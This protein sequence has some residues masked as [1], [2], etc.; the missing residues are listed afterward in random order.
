MEDFDKQLM[1]EFI[2]NIQ[3]LSQHSE[4]V[5][6]LLMQTLKLLSKLGHEPR[7]DV[8]G[9]LRFG[10]DQRLSVEK[11]MGR[12]F[13]QI[14]ELTELV[15]TSALITTS[16]EIKH[17]LE[18]VVDTVI[19][20]TGAERAFLM[21]IQDMGAEEI[22]LSVKAARNDQGQDIALEEVTFSRGIIKTA[23]DQREPIISTNAQEDERFRAMASVMRH[24]LRSIMVIPM[25]LQGVPLGVLYLDNR[26]ASAVF[27]KKSIPILTAFAN[28]AAIAIENARLF[29]RVQSNLERTQRELKR[30][31]IQ[32]DE[33][34]M[35][36]QVDQIT[37]S[38]YFRELAATAKDLRRGRSTE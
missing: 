16:L 28:Q 5:E 11:D 38:D 14:E 33:Q 8:E 29:E 30:L 36:T 20:L 35:R 2:E 4:Q 19:H 1:T 12:V 6:N 26:L 34:K 7:V 17:V 31:R 21:L 23:I 25:L 27:H 15:R 37:E 9:I 13:Q 32:I 24:D 18:E 22:D 3:G 10:R